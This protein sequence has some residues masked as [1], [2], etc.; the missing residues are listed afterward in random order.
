MNNSWILGSAISNE[1]REFREGLIVPVSWLIFDTPNH[2]SISSWLASV[3]I[4][5]I[6]TSVYIL[7]VSI[8]QNGSYFFHQPVAS[9]WHPSKVPYEPSVSKRG[10]LE[11]LL[12]CDLLVEDIPWWYRPCLPSL[13]RA[14]LELVRQ[15]CCHRVTNL[16]VVKVKVAPFWRVRTGRPDRHVGAKKTSPVPSFF[17]QVGAI[18]SL[19]LYQT[20]P[21]N[22][23]KDPPANHPQ[24]IASVVVNISKSLLCFVDQLCHCGILH[25]TGY[26]G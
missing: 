19:F 11:F 26:Y 16:R 8:L 15:H 22:S 9:L 1:Q 14:V 25:R 20:I 4:C 7:Y 21:K 24:I 18:I 3:F 12:L 5:L 23:M 2:Q 17:H 10:A 13:W 6:F